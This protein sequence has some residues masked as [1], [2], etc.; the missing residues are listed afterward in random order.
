M[1]HVGFGNREGESPREPSSV[2]VNS[3]RD[4]T[5]F[6]LQLV[7]LGGEDWDNMKQMVVM[8]EIESGGLYYEANGSYCGR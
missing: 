3:F 7:L 6:W 5:L 4:Q 2:M 1:R 8:R